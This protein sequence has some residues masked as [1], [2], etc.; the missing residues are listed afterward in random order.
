MIYLVFFDLG[1][2]GVFRYNVYNIFIVLAWE[3]KMKLLA[4]LILACSISTSFAQDLSFST[5]SEQTKLFSSV[6]KKQQSSS[7]KLN[8]ND[9]TMGYGGAD[10]SRKL[11]TASI[12]EIA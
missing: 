2:G 11:P 1:G 10:V 7:P 6:W 5:V 9:I 8:K 3:D 12:A 4:T